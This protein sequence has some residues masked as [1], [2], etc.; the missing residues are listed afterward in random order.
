M[1]SKTSDSVV[2]HIDCSN[3]G[4]KRLYLAWIQYLF[5]LILDFYFLAL[6]VSIPRLTKIEILLLSGFKFCIKRDC[7]CPF[8]AL[9]DS[10]ELIRLRRYKVLKEAIKSFSQN[11]NNLKPETAAR[12]DEGVLHMKL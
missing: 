11:R 2:K 10:Y 4:C 5:F 9:P 1:N 7:A 8:S 6:N 3:C 12:I